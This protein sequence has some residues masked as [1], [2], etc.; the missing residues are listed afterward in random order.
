MS[1]GACDDGRPDASLA[2][3]T[4]LLLRCTVRVCD[5]G[6]WDKV[7]V[8]QQQFVSPQH[9]SRHVYAT[10]AIDMVTCR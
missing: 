3:C 6:P 1:V 5:S 9:N 8:V 2:A 7:A 10:V 4:S